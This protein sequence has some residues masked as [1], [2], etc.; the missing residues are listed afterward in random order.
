[1]SPQPSQVDVRCAQWGSLYK[2]Q[3]P[4]WVWSYKQR[5]ESLDKINFYLRHAKDG[6][7][8]ALKQQCKI[9][10]LHLDYLRGATP[11]SP[12]TP[13]FQPE[14]EVE[15]NPYLFTGLRI[16]EFFRTHDQIRSSPDMPREKCDQLLGAALVA[17]F[18]KQ[19]KTARIDGERP[20]S[21]YE[22]FMSV[23]CPSIVLSMI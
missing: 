14:P 20:S 15:L 10:L 6:L 13:W 8:E 22:T 18:A 19:R 5:Q 9:Q 11:S 17:E 21:A 16:G 23:L 12:G 3:E 2:R 4:L 7:T 1:M